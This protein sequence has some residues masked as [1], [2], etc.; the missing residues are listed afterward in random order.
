MNRLETLM[1]V[2]AAP[3]QRFEN[4]C[5]QMLTQR[6]VDTAV[7]VQLDLLG[8]IVGQ[9]R[10]GLSDDVYRRYIRA[11]VLTNRATGKREE[12][13]SIAKLILGSPVGA[14]VVVR[15]QSIATVFV[16]IDGVTVDAATEAALILFLGDAVGQGIRIEVQS[17]EVL[18]SGAFMYDDAS[19]PGTY[20][21]VGYDNTASPGGGGAYS[22]VRSN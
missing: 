14:I 22:D 20:G 9:G 1:T 19:A 6:T 16:R 13:I 7:G 11:R 18:D 2:L 10:Q 3:F 5:I 21:T 8:K 17:S 4:A 15:D 12:L